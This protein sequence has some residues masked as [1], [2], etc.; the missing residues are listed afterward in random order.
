MGKEGVKAGEKYDP[1]NNIKANPVKK[2]T[3]QGSRF[4]VLNTEITEIRVKESLLITTP[5]LLLVVC[6]LSL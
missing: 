3:N 2:S 1:K 5:I 6:H 4:S